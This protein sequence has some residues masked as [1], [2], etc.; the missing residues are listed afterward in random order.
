MPSPG[1]VWDGHEVFVMGTV[2]KNPSS[3]SPTLLA[4]D[5]ATDVLRKIDISNAPIAAQ[6]Q[7]KLI[8]VSGS[9]LVFSTEGLA[10][11]RIFIVRYDPTTDSWS[12]KGAFAPFPV[13][14]G[15]Y[16]QTAWLGDRYAAA[17]GSSGLQ[18]YSLDSDAWEAITPGTIAAQLAGGQRNRLDGSQPHR[19]ERHR[20]RALQPHP[21]GWRLT[22][23][24]RLT[25]AS[26]LQDPRYRHEPTSSRR[27]AA[28][29]C[30]PCAG[31]S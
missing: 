22:R 20:V 30:A 3:C 12:K 6:Q 21:G 5:P 31:V 16:T 25:A 17:D 14:V 1:V 2:C 19:V 18:I 11:M 24:A 29:S 15:A 9:D 4:Y 23:T 28:P 7:L 10:N 13:P 8:G 27:G 26:S